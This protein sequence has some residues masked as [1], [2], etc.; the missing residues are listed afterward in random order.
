MTRR[1][2]LKIIEEGESL[3]VE[4]KQ[5]YSEHEKIAKEII[6]F[7]NTAGGYLIFGVEDNG[8]IT[9]VWSE[10][11]TAE[12]LTECINNHIE[13]TPEYTIHYIDVDD[14]ELVVAE[15]FESEIKPNRVQDYKA[16]LDLRTAQVYVRQA[17]K[18]I[19][20][21]REM[22]KILQAQSG[23]K[24]LIKYEIGKNEKI[25]FEYLEK[26]EYITV[27]QLEEIANLS[28]RRASRT[29]IKMVRADLLF[30]HTRNNGEDFYT[31]TGKI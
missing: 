29:L 10:K 25:V 31:H 15:I 4:F 6:A 23:E 22:I 2:L 11:E 26:N 3:T 19:P 28:R 5:R 9:G 27:K 17:D 12:L 30:I 16:E 8:K 21:S 18:S 20:A 1:Q 14:V 24:P 13:P 7:A